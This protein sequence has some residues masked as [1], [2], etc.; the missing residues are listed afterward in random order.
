M[1]DTH[2]YPQI[3]TQMLAQV[4]QHF[5]KNSIRGIEMEEIAELLGINKKYLYQLVSSKGELVAKCATF[6][7]GHF[8]KTQNDLAE[9]AKD[10]IHEFFLV[11]ESIVQN[12][13]N[14]HPKFFKDLKKYYPTAHKIYSEFHYKFNEEFITR[15]LNQGLDQKIYREDMDLPLLVRMYLNTTINLIDDE[16]YPFDRFSYSDSRTEFI[17]TYVLGLVNEQGKALYVQYFD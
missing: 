1:A 3:T 2:D 4:T 11:N 6:I 7:T 10:P 14:M 8:S 16:N 5:I 17:K 15:N 12:Y 9:Q 13:G